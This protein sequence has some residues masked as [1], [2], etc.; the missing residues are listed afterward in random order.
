MHGQSG[1]RANESNP[2][3]CSLK[4]PAQPAQAWASRAGSRGDKCRECCWLP[5]LDHVPS[6]SIAG[7][8]LTRA[9]CRSSAP[10][11]DTKPTP[12]CSSSSIVASRSV[13][14]LPQRSSR[15]TR[16]TS[17]SR[18]RAASGSFSRNWRWVDLRSVNNLT[19]H[20]MAAMAEY[21]TK[22]ISEHT[23]VTLAAAKARGTKLGFHS[24]KGD[25]KR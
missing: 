1:M 23:E 8:T 4:L 19:V 16:T 6:Y 18:R 20:I 22:A 12:R 2:L 11:S 24:W 3:G 25:G 21:E 5:V 14:D 10:V 7:E 13:T 17:I 15:R 9:K